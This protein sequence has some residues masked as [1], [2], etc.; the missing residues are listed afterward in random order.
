[1][2]TSVKNPVVK[3]I[4]KLH[5]GKY[6][7]SHQEFLLEGTHLI[8]EALHATYPLTMV[9]MTPAW[10]VKHS[11]LYPQLQHH[12][13][14][15]VPVSE[16]VLAAMTTTVTPDGIVAIAPFPGEHAPLPARPSLAI[17]L[18]TLQNPGNLGTVIRTAA[19]V[20][21]DGLWLSADSVDPFHPKV[22]RA[23]SGQWFQVPITTGDHLI[24]QIHTW[25]AQGCQVLATCVTNAQPYWS[26]DLRQPTVILLGN[27]G[28]GLS[29]EVLGA[30]T[31]R[32]HIPMATSV[33]SLNVGVA[34][35]VILFEAARQRAISS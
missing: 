5:Q 21:C 9:C 29:E 25:Q 26:V 15:I 6:R 30:A 14:S 32:I 18:E 8:Q 3:H 7:R 16:E 4:K 31:Q 20:G 35:A 11:D 19:A 17:A 1:M 24:P 22:L 27:E 23:S 12:A 13:S 2:L 33:E 28:A 10:Q 34:A